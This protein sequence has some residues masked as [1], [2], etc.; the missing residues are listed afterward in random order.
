MKIRSYLINENKF[1]K[2]VVG[3]AFWDARW[4]LYFGY[5]RTLNVEWQLFHRARSHFSCTTELGHGDGDDGLM[6]HMAIPWIFSVFISFDGIFGTLFHHPNEPREVGISIFDGAI[7]FYPFSKVNSW[8]SKDP[9]YSQSHCFRLI[10]F[11]F[12]RWKYTEENVDPWKPI[13]VA[14]PEGK[15]K[16]K[17]RL[18]DGVWKN[19]IR[20]KR[21]RR[22]EIEMEEGIPVP[23]KG[24]NSWDCGEDAFHGTTCPAITPEEAICSLIEGV[25]RDRRK[26][27]NY[28]SMFDYVPEQKHVRYKEIPNGKNYKA[29]V[30]SS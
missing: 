20:T 15:Y 28:N 18:Y 29:S 9:W 17:L 27:G 4:F 22:G 3:S 6:L 12:G 2:S 19:R 8:N 14:M 23:G 13:V 1:G 26:Y 7:W 10:E 11:L 24:E 21:I 30:E 25:M 5:K 16:G